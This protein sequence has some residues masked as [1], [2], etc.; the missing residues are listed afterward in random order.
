MIF[1]WD[2]RP[3]IL[4]FLFGFVADYLCDIDLAKMF[5]LFESFALNV[6]Q[7]D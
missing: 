6:G 5:R 3:N 7:N 4:D 2:L 1:P